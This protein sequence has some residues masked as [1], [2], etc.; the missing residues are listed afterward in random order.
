MQT[1]QAQTQMNKDTAVAQYGLNAT[2][3]ITPYGNLTYKQIGTWDDGTPRFEATQ[4]LSPE[5]QNLYNNYTKLA[6]QF[7]AIGNNQAANVA[8]TLSQPFNFDAA[9]ATKLSNIQDTFLNPQFDRQSAALETKL[10]NQGVTP[11]STAY[12]DA[13]KQLNLQQ[14]DARNSNYLSAYDT[15]SRQALA[16]RQE[17]LNELTA[18]LSGS[19][20][21][22]PNFVNTPT[23]GVAPVDYTGLVQNQYQTQVGN[24]NA[25]YGALGGIGGTLLGGWAYGGGLKNLF[26]A[27]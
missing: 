7:G 5:E 4:T 19:Q 6:G 27:K 12:N 25:L 16:E 23:P 1:A 20:V 24:Q 3:Q 21:Q 22:N 2:N 15:A 8:S 18:L 11:G 9:A 26:G 14:Q 17:P 13:F 10:A